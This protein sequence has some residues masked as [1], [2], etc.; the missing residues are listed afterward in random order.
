[1][2]TTLYDAYG[3]PVDFGKLK[4]ELAAPTI[5]GVRS[6]HSAHP[7][8]GLTPERLASLLRNAEFGDPLHYL[9]LAEEMEEKDLH[10]LS[11]M[12]TRKRA[13]SQLD[14]TVEAASDDKNDVKVADMVR[15]WIR[16]EELEDELFDILDAI[17]KGFSVTEIMWDTTVTP[18]WP[19]AL[20]WRDPRWFRFNLVDGKT[21][22]LRDNAGYIPLAPFKFIQHRIRAKSGLTI[23][24][25]LARASA[26]SYLFKNY[27]VKDWVTFA[28]VYGQPIRVGKY[29]PGATEPEKEILLRAV[30]NIGSDAAAII[31][32]SMLIEF[33][34]NTSKGSSTD[35]YERFCDFLDRQVS[36]AV[37]GQTLTTEVKDGGSY[38][39]AKVHDDVRQDIKRSDARQLG[40]C[41]NRDFVRPFIDL[42]IGPQKAYP[43]ILIG[44]S[45]SVQ[46]KDFSDAVSALVDRG[47][48]VNQS[49][50]RDRIGIPDVD[51]EADMLHPAREGGASG[52]AP[53]DHAGAVASQQG[54]EVTDSID[55]LVDDALD[56]WEPLMEPLLD[57]IEEILANAATLDEVQAR[58]ADAIRDMDSTAFEELLARAGFAAHLAGEVEAPIDDSGVKP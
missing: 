28:E 4:E 5:T 37:L 17:G 18:W 52:A 11:V 1:M 50:I 21:I 6:I 47:L 41:L 42:N 38:A 40:A 10:Y 32:Q 14:I 56:G 25:G 16:R 53:E 45:T 9:E 43:R 49:I 19:K 12:G 51:E 57:P 36:K 39:A 31:P 55:D 3:N 35:L 29:H 33:I 22:E 24:G 27:S 20:E 13:V 34:D 58:L 48:K 44:I 54:A 2:A 30:A 23:R 8:Q 46:L 7:A 15:E 26:W